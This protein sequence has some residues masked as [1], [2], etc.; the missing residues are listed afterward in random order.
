MKVEKVPVNTIIDK[1]LKKALKLLGVLDEKKENQILENLIKKECI[2]SG[3]D[4]GD[5]INAVLKEG[6]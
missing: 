6:K 3:Y 5:E 4:F 2:E 1:R